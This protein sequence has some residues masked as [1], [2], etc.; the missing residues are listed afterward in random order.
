MST[1]A[2]PN[3]LIQ[4]FECA[5][6]TLFRGIRVKG[7][8]NIEKQ[9]RQDL[10]TLLKQYVMTSDGIRFAVIFGEGLDG[11]C[12]YIISGI[13]PIDTNNRNKMFVSLVDHHFLESTTPVLEYINGGAYYVAILKIDTCSV[14][15]H[16]ILATVESLSTI[17]EDPTMTQLASLLDHYVG[18][19][20]IGCNPMSCP[21]CKIWR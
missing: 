19:M 20:R 18:R 1:K 14:H 13:F 3:D 21:N 9:L 10:I 8:S 17:P 7:F 11:N 12:H 2:A 4:C 6:E 15:A 5:W 16:N